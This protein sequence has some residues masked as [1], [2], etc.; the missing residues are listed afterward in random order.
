M[1]GHETHM[2]GKAPGDYLGNKSLDLPSFKRSKRF[3]LPKAATGRLPVLT[4]RNS[5]NY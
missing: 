3:A 5:P 4:E 2:L 1:P